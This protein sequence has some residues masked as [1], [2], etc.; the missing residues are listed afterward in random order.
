MSLRNFENRVSNK[1]AALIIG[2]FSVGIGLS[3][4]S[5]Y[6]HLE[7]EKETD[8]LKN[9]FTG[10]EVILITTALMILGFKKANK[11]VIESHVGFVGYIFWLISNLPLFLNPISKLAEFYIIFVLSIIGWFLIVTTFLKK[12]KDKELVDNALPHIRKFFVVLVIIAIWFY[13]LYLVI[14]SAAH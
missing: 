10:A 5:M 9:T 6:I 14:I 11:Y 4:I 8:V 13:A 2:L 3:I 7:T 1:T 12:A